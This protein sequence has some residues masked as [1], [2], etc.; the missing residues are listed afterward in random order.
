MSYPNLR[1]SI[2]ALAIAGASLHIHANTIVDI[3]E[4]AK[5]FSNQ[6]PISGPLTVIGTY[7]GESDVFELEET[8]L[9]GNLT[10]DAD[11]TS[12]ISSFP[13]A[14]LSAVVFEDAYIDGNVLNKGSL[15]AIGAH[16]EA[17][18]MEETTLTGNLVNE[19]IIS[20]QGTITPSSDSQ[21]T[22]L[23]IEESIIEGSIQNSGTIS[24]SATGNAE[25]GA[26][27]I[28]SGIT[29][30]GTAVKKSVV[31]SGDIEVDGG[32]GST[33]TA[34]ILVEGLRLRDE[35]TGEILPDI[36]E[37]TVIEGQLSNTGAI[38]V[39]GNNATGI[40]IGEG[41]TLKD[42][43][44]NSGTIQGET[45][46]IHVDGGTIDS[47]VNTGTITASSTAIVIDGAKRTDESIANRDFHLKIEHKDGLISGGRAAIDA[48]G[49][50]VDLLW[51]GGK[52]EGDIRGL[53]GYAQVT[54]SV[55]FD[56][57]LI[58]VGEEVRVGRD[59]TTGHLELLADHTTIKGKLE[60]ANGSSV[61]L[62]LSSTTD[63]TKPVL[64]VT[65]TAEFAQGSKLIIQAR[66]ADFVADGSSYRLVAAQ[67]IIDNGL[68][69]ES[70]NQLLKVSGLQISS[71]EIGG[72]L[73]EQEPG[74]APVD[75]VT[76]PQSGVIDVVTK[77]PEE[78]R[79]TIAAG[80]G[81]QNAQAASAALSSIVS[82]APVHVRNAFEGVTE[83]QAAQIVEQVTPE[84]NGGATQA[85]MTGQGLISNVTGSRTSSIRGMSSGDSFKETGA[86]AQALYSDANQDLRDGVAGYNA[87]S[88]GIAIGVDGKLNDQLTLGVAY[89]YLDTD[90][91][92][93]TGNKTEVEGHAFTLY[94]GYE[95]G[96]YFVDANLTY[97]I[98]NNEGERYVFGEKA[99]SDYDSSVLGVNVTGGYSYAVNE[100]LVVEPRLATRYSRVDIDS[101]REKGAALALA[102]D[103]QRY[104]VF[105]LGAG[106]R[107]AAQ[108]PLGKGVL[109]PH[110]SLM[111]FHDF[112]A[113]Q[114]SSVSTFVLGGTPFVTNG[115]KPVRDS[116]EAG[117]GG[118]YQ[119]GQFSVGLGYD[120][121]GKSGFNADT[122]T[123]KLRYDF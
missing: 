96:R 105:E 106:V 107:V 95:L 93:K 52:I 1:R 70:S 98:N 75:P 47:I 112:A 49:G 10:L 102:T 59:A 104:E 35:Y 109:E 4:G 92:S 94:A 21:I 20:V 67:K 46:G 114:A 115:A 80:G 54:N 121:V 30:A 99:K 3:S 86:W 73:D 116:Y 12:N 36:E 42:G 60:V 48:N 111:A 88:R 34:G 122:V 77:T 79:K 89:S 40:L 78:F 113:D 101:Y 97:G 103:D 118:T 24:G 11:I 61:G 44:H 45:R 58:E 22:A 41:A 19:G 51:S 27:A 38:V 53:G 74:T 108:Y 66:E 117:I 13:G 14:P 33:V 31:N 15:T 7:T 2:L 8:R 65:K 37:T 63:A 17:V 100:N 26:P 110:V 85:A 29:I 6:P 57:N 123:A 64:D 81:S 32:A 9:N 84:T 5:E 69:V 23:N 25:P 68:Q 18:E 90:V 43:L 16:A 120:Y 28:V 56:G 76:P 39:K 72:G 55:E 91:N 82:I 87:Y 83:A 50:D 71:T 62:N 119:V